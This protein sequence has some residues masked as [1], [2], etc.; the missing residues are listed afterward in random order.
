MHDQPERITIDQRS[1]D[2]VGTINGEDGDLMPP[3][4][5]SGKDEQTQ[6]QRL[7]YHGNARLQRH[8]LGGQGL[9]GGDIARN[10]Y[11]DQHVVEEQIG[12]RCRVKPPVL[13]MQVRKAFCVVHHRITP[14]R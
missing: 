10:R 3:K 1:T 8:K 4:H 9:D 14:D 11:L 2:P 12:N 13:Y 6:K 5:K 7:C